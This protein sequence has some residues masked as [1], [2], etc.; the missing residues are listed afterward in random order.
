M[1]VDEPLLRR[2]SP[3]SQRSSSW[4]ATRDATLEVIGV[5]D[6]G[7]V[8]LATALVTGAMG[9]GVTAGDAGVATAGACGD[10][11]TTA[12]CAAVAS[13]RSAASGRRTMAATMASMRAP[14][15]R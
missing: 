5:A 10:T 11:G 14:R 9:R 6:V 13:G 12:A 15:V 1:L 2:T 7:G 3:A 4:F 8:T